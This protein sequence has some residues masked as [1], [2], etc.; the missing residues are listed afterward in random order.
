MKSLDQIEARTPI[1]SAP[2]TINATGSY[3]LTGSLTVAGGDAITIAADNVSL[4]LNGFTITS[5]AASA[6]GS[7]ILL[8]GTRRNITVRNGFIASGVTDNGGVYSGSGFNSGIFYSGNLPFNVRVSGISV[9]GCKSYGIYLGAGSQ[10][11]SAVEFCS[12]YIAGLAGIYANDVSHSNVFDCG[13]N[14]IVADTATDCYG[15]VIASGAAGVTAVTATNCRGRSDGTGIGISATTAI[16][17]YGTSVSSQGISATT[18]SNCWGFSSTS[19]GIGAETAS[20]CYGESNSNRGISTDVAMG[21]SGASHGGSY[22]LFA[23]SIANTCYGLSNTGT[24]INA[25]ILIGCIGANGSGPSVGYTYHY[26]M[27]P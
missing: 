23:T 15:Q 8:S 18:A 3:F 13:V 21:C 6:T 1:S 9:S 2:F 5:T 4:D 10:N 12:V 17:C 14:A 27:P 16:N 11:T 25:V 20:N 7:G 19:Q 24:G 22:G 26:N